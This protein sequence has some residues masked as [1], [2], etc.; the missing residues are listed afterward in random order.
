M[1][2]AQQRTQIRNA[3]LLDL[4]AASP[5]SLPKST[6]GSNLRSVHAIPVSDKQLDQHLD[7]FVGEG[8]V[9]AIP[10]RFSPGDVRYKLSSAGRLYLEESGQI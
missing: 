4:E 7:L 2:E 8:V 10:Q 3:L 6:T 9:E 5:A 1:T